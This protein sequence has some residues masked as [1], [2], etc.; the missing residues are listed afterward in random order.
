[1]QAQPQR[2]TG[3]ASVLIVAMGLFGLASFFFLKQS[4]GHSLRLETCFQDVSGLRS[5]S[6]V[7]LAGVEVGAVRDVRAQPSNRACP[8]AVEMELRTPYDLKIPEDSVASIATSG[9]LGETYL[10]ID[11]SAASRPPIQAG[12]RL[13]GKESVKFTAETVD[14]AVKAVQ[15]LKQLSDDERSAAAEVKTA[16]TRKPK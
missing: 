13:P 3:W 11:V 14:R 4:A 16:S 10:E 12:G 8:G 7:R 5:G 15:T 6:R 2:S 9:L 1:M